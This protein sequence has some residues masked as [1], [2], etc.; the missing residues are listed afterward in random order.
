MVDKAY[1]QQRDLGFVPSELRQAFSDLNRNIISQLGQLNPITQ[2]MSK[3]CAEY[4]TVLNML[5]YR[6]TAEF[7]DLSVELFGHPKDLFHAGEPSL[8]ELANMLELPLK[9]LLAADLLPDD[10]KNIDA[11][12]AVKILAEQVKKR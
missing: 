6:G 12:A 8:S 7:H 11:D 1:Y 10:P 9:N 2:Y 4:K 5:E 3:M